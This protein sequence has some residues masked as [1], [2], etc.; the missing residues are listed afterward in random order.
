MRSKVVLL[1]F[2]VLLLLVVFAVSFSS[3]KEHKFSSVVKPCEA[4]HEI[5]CNNGENKAAGS[6]Y[7]AY[8]YGFEDKIKKALVEDSDPV[9]VFF[10]GVSKRTKQPMWDYYNLLYAKYILEGGFLPRNQKKDVERL[11]TR[12]KH[13]VIKVVEKAG[14][15]PSDLR[16]TL[17][18]ECKSKSITFGIP[19]HLDNLTLVSDAISQIQNRFFDLKDNAPTGTDGD[20]VEFY[21]KMLQLAYNAYAFNESGVDVLG[22]RFFTKEYLS[23]EVLYTPNEHFHH[24]KNARGYYIAWTFMW[25]IMDRAGEHMDPAAIECYKR[26]ASV[27]CLDYKDWMLAY[28]SFRL[29]SE[30]LLEERSPSKDRRVRIDGSECEFCEAQDFMITFQLQFCDDDEFSSADHNNTY[31]QYEVFQRAFGC[32]SGGIEDKCNVF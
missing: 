9:L 15:I 3:S 17:V 12:V 11:F 25:I 29:V 14:W 19:D 6:L 7:R 13:R 26:K 16:S 2:P 31:G 22:V 5:V 24:L 21:S 27:S 23:P 32:S 1:V 28:E 8:A 4:F 20:Q 18:E 10:D 30:M